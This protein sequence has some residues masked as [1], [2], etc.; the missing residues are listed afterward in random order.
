MVAFHGLGIV[1]DAET[2]EIPTPKPLQ[3]ALQ[4]VEFPALNGSSIEDD[5]S[6]FG[7]NLFS[8]QTAG[9]IQPAFKI[10]C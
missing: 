5:Q 6:L 9:K 7:F 1:A 4:N 2:P 8:R 3:E 10:R